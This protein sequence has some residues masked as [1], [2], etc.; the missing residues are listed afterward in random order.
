MVLLPRNILIGL[1]LIWR[2]AISPLYGDVCRYYPSCSSY[3]LQALQ[4]LGVIRGAPLTIWRILRC[5]PWSPGGIDEPKSGPLW[6]RVGKL[7]FVSP[8][9]EE[10][11]R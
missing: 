5:N 8:A 9:S 11:L 7:G 6:I 3:G 10:K 4:N 2:K 1:V